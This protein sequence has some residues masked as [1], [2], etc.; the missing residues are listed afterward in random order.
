MQMMIALW[1]TRSIAE[2]IPG[3]GA[4]FNGRPGDGTVS[5]S[6]KSIKKKRKNL[7]LVYRQKFKFDP[8]TLH[9]FEF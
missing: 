3:W 5:V 2:N 4:L 9:G 7:L 8:L 1:M 6:K